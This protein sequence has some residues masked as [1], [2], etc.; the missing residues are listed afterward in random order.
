MTRPFASGGWQARLCTDYEWSGTPPAIDLNVLQICV[1][2]HPLFEE[3][4]DA[5]LDGDPAAAALA[6]AT[7]EGQKV[8]RNGG[9]SWRA[10]F[11]RI[12]ASQ[13]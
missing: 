13:R 8:A 4:A 3:V 5:E 1:Q 11:R 7:E 10:V 6:T 2:A 9:K 12:A